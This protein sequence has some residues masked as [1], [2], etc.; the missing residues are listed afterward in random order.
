MKH[1]GALTIGD[2]TEASDP[3]ALFGQ[4]LGEAAQAEPAN[5]D[6]AALATVDADGLP[7]VRMV[8]VKG[9]DE[10]GF[11]FYTHADSAKGREL[12]ARPQAALALYWKTLNRQIRARGTIERVTEAEADAYF[13]TRPRGAQ[14]GAWA[15][16]QSEPL[17]RR[18]QLAQAVAAIEK[19]Y[20]GKP[21][22]RPPYWT[23]FRLVPAE[24]EFWQE[25]KFRLHDRVLFARARGS[26]AWTKKR[27]Y[28]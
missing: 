18:E 10:R 28:P 27:L 6:A 26:A 1:P 5:P 17:E 22:P 13:A 12:A 24:I 19:K 11:V 3:F 4:W 20:E 9:A 21:V 16:R 15:S 23:G 14:V 7:N 8:L 2:F 25:G